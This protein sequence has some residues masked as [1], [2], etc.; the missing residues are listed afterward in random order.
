VLGWKSASRAGPV[1]GPGDHVHAG[2]RP[3]AVGQVEGV[4]AAATADVQA[5]P[6]G[7]ASGPD[8]GADILWLLT[9]PWTYRSLVSHR[10]WSLDQYEAWIADTLH[11]LLMQPSQQPAHQSTPGTE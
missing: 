8:R 11:A 2:D 6:T 4:A 10:G 9:G 3:A 1:Q 7:R 5:L